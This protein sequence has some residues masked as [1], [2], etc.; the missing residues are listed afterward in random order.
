[1]CEQQKR[2]PDDVPAVIAAQPAGVLNTM[3]IGLA[4]PS[5]VGR[6]F[7]EAHRNRGLLQRRAAVR[8]SRTATIMPSARSS[9]KEELV[10]AKKSL[11]EAIT[12][13]HFN[14]IVVRLAWHDSGSYDKVGSWV[15]AFD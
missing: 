6:A 2:D 8:H 11:A 15:S 4:M 14:P 1:M 5:Y 12:S 9:R 13:K 3:S 7:R 10:K